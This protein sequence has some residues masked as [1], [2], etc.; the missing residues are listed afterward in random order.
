MKVKFKNF[1]LSV[2]II[3]II[4]GIVQLNT[5]NNTPQQAIFMVILIFIIFLIVYRIA[6]VFPSNFEN[7]LEKNNSKPSIILKIKV[8][9]ISIIQK[10]I[11]RNNGSG[12]NAGP[13]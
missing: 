1:I 7:T 3:L 11:K 4:L 13:M 10:M 6:I 5:G 8:R 9:S 2:L 12:P